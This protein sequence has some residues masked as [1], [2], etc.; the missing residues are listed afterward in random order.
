MRGS[1]SQESKIFLGIRMREDTEIMARLETKR[2]DKDTILAR[3]ETKRTVKTGSNK[4]II[5]DAK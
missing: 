2:A 5:T 1:K 3:L 4:A